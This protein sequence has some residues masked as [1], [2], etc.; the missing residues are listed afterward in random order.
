V[1]GAAGWAAGE[2]ADEEEAEEAGDDAEEPAPPV[3][4][5]WPRSAKNHTAANSP[6]TTSTI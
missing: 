1:D 4:V 2:G 6:N 5:E 3:L